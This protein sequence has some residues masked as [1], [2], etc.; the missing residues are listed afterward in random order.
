MDPTR[1]HHAPHPL[2]PGS[3][4]ACYSPWLKVWVLIRD[5]RQGAR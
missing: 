2:A 1:L 3:Q 5:Q 4:T